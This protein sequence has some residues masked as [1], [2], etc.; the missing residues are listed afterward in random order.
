MSNEIKIGSIFVSSWGYDQTNICFY[1]VINMTKCT[2][3]VRELKN[4]RIAKPNCMSAIVIPS[5]EFYGRE[6]YKKRVSDRGSE[7]ISIRINESE[8]AYL[9]T[10]EQLEKGFRETYTG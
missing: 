10:P 7:Y 8:R 6:I 9:K 3:T 4:E 5:K 1:V 2:V